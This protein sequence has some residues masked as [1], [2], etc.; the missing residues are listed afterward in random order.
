MEVAWRS[1]IFMA[2]T[3]DEMLLQIKFNIAEGED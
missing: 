2:L 3:G 1:F